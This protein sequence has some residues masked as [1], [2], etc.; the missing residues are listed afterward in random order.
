[1]KVEFDVCIA[2][3]KRAIGDLHFGSSVSDVVKYILMVFFAKR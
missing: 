3:E 1:M 2:G